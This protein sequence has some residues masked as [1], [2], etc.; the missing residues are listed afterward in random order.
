MQFC[1]DKHGE[2]VAVSASDDEN[3]EDEKGENGGFC[4]RKNEQHVKKIAKT[5]AD[6]TT[7]LDMLNDT[8][9]NAMFQRAIE[10]GIEMWRV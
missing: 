8:K 1:L 9:R 6:S 4:G 5:L 10:N 3:K 7:W 2:W